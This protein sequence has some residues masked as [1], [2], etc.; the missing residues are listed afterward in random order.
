MNEFLCKVSVV[1]GI[2]YYYYD[3]AAYA[4]IAASYIWAYSL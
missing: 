1:V 2:I 3:S 4:A